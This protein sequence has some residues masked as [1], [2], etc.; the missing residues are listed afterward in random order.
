MTRHFTVLE[1]RG[2]LAVTG[3]DARDFL[4]G[5]ISQD[6]AHASASRSAHGAFLTPQ[7]K[8]LHEFFL[9]AR[10]DADMWL[11]GEA[12][13]LDDLKTRLSRFRLRADVTLEA[14]ND[15]TVLALWGAGTAEAL[16]LPE[17]AGAMAP[18]AGGV[19]FVDPR[20]A[21]MGA[22]AVVPGDAAPPG[23]AAA[24]LADWDAHR[25]ALGVP[26]GNRDLVVD[27]TILLEANFDAL[28]GLDWDKGCYMGQELT[29]RTHYRGLIK[30]RLLPVRIDGAPP[31][32]GT[33]IADASGATVGDLR[34]SADGHG[35]ALLRLEAVAAA[36]A[37]WPFRAGDVRIAPVRP[38]WL[39]AD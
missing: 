25:L 16:G 2:V 1:H 11:E 10:G 15:V 31:P 20:L 17:T 26:D 38:D 32:P 5:L 9:I 3:P 14:V 6:V 39:P 18:Y 21:A 22:R 34:S 37:E 27:K 24:A 8:F 28:A 13:R 12:A 23:F 7:G 35:L 33:A 19:A 36:D 30:K 29:A 4:Q